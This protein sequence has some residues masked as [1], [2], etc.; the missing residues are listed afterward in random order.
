MEEIDIEELDFDDYNRQVYLEESV[1]KNHISKTLDIQKRYKLE[2][3]KFIADYN[4][5]MAEREINSNTFENN[6]KRKI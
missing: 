5:A 1:A 6:K 4:K 3:N 2:I